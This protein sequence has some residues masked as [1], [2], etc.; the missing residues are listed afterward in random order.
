MGEAWFCFCGLSIILNPDISSKTN[1][2]VHKLCYPTSKVTP[3]QDSPAALA[4][5]P[6]A[7]FRQP[8]R[9]ESRR[10]N[11]VRVR[12]CL[13]RGGA[14]LRVPSL[15]LRVPPHHPESEN[16]VLYPDLQKGRPRRPNTSPGQS[17]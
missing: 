8:P 9:S 6:G 5:W 12:H 15:Q 11:G 14:H 7:L 3:F 2:E 10:G 17:L 16:C 13:D 4:R 1:G